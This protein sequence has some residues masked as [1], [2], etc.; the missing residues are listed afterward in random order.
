MFISLGAVAVLALILTLPTW[1]KAAAPSKVTRPALTVPSGEAAGPVQLPPSMQQSVQVMVELKDAPAAATWAAA[2]K[3]AQAQAD[4]QRNYALAHPT[5]KTSQALLKTTPQRVQISSTSAKQIQSLAKNIDSTQKALLP[6]LTGGNISGQ[7]IFRT[8]MAYNGIAMIVNPAN[9]SNILKL[10]GVKAVHPMVPKTLVTAFSDIDFL[11]A[12]GAWTKD[13]LAGNTGDG[14]VVADIDTGLDYIHRNYGGSGSSSDYSSTSDT[15]AVPNANFPTPKIPAG[16]D[17]VGDAYNA[18]NPLSIPVPDNNPYD[19]G[20]HGT[21]TASL[22]AGYGMTN[23]GFT[24]AGNYDASNPSMSTLKCS[25]GMAPHAKIIPLRVFGCAGSTNVVT[26]ALEWVM[27]YNLNMAVAGYPAGPHNPPF[28]HVVNMSLGANEGFADDADDVAA[29]N[30]AST[31]VIICSAAGNAGDSFYIHSSPAAA[32]GTLGVAATFNDQGGFIFDS[33]V[34]GNTP[35]AIAGTKFF[36]IKGSAS[37]AIPGG[38]ITGNVVHAVPFIGNNGGGL[39]NAANVNGNICVIDR[40]TF[41]FTSKVT[42]CLNAGATAVIVQNATCNPNCSVPILMSTAGQPAGVDVMISNNDYGTINTAA[43]GFNGTTGVPANPTNVTI[44][45]DGGAQIIPALAAPDTIPTYS[46]RGPR[47]PD[48]ATKPDIAAPAEVVGVAQPFSGNGIENFNGTSS[49]TPHVAGMMALLRQLHPTWTVQE[50]MALACGT[51]THDLFTTTAHTTEYG[52]GRIG[53]GRIDITN[54]ANANVVAYNGSDANLIGVSFGPVEVPIG[55]ST[56]LTKNIT[57]ENKGA[58]NE[59]YNTS[60]VNNPNV[61]GL[62]TTF[63]VSPSN[64]TVNAGTSTTLTVTLTATGNAITHQRDPSVSS[65]QLGVQREWLTEAGGYAVLTPTDSSPTLRVELYANPK[66]SSSMHATTSGFVPTSANTGSFTINLSGTGVVNNGSTASRNVKSLVKAFELQYTNPFVG[67]PNAPTD[68]NVIKYA[69]VT[70]D[71]ITGSDDEIMFGVEKFGAAATPDA[72]SSDTEIFFDTNPA[73]I[74]VSFTPNYAVFLGN[75]GIP[76]GTAGAENVFFPIVVNLSTSTIVG[77][78]DFTNGM[79][80]VFVD[81]N[82]FNNS[83][84]VI[85]MF[86]SLMGVGQF[87]GPSAPTNFQYQVV[88]FDRN[89]HEVDQSPV[90]YYDVANPGLE[91]ENS[92]HV[93][94]VTQIFGGGGPPFEGFWYQDVPTNIIPVN[95][96]GANF[97][98]NGSIGVWLFHTH[99]ADGNRSDVVRFL[100]PTITGFSP[101]SGHVGDFITITGSNFNAGTTV[102]FFNNDNATSVNVITSTTISVQV[103]AGAT[104]GPIRVSNAAGSSAKAGFTVL[105]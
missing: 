75:L 66:P 49:A 86:A 14:V 52:V 6:S 56:T 12:R 76:S 61:S 100:P 40:G 72:A 85:P 67:Q 51:A 41:S 46:S 26:Q 57:V 92:S 74:G 9:I 20:G 36:S 62:G 35:P 101:T 34:T 19:C 11:G 91:V 105:P 37:A 97:Q 50:L 53:A 90:L 3:Q 55:G 71:Y 81:T 28:I 104:S 68:R 89:G 47:L 48:S 18:N 44:N 33:N 96:N 16:W 102:T 87:A 22:I 15:S 31:G 8:Q 10:S 70:T 83:G 5:L 2:L 95:W 43:G 29:S 13:G 99:N 27:G 88:T 17:F 54:A 84:I 32:G 42:D 94:G 103:P 63:T 25:P 1:A 45:N 98:T 4:A 78:T 58:T 21:A 69:G 82:I 79:T 7:V 24:Y 39:S 65:T 38:G 30:L 60:V 59:T 80:A 23:A 64:F 73:D 77:A 93:A